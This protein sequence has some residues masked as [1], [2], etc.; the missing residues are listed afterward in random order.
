V[1]VGR[2]RGW[3]V[4]RFYDMDEALQWLADA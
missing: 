3:K 2:N 4:Q 1:D